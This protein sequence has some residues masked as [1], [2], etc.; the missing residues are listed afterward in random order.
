MNML[1]EI[2]GECVRRGDG[3]CRAGAETVARRGADRGMY[4]IVEY[5]RAGTTH[6][7]VCSSRVYYESVIRLANRYGRCLRAVYLAGGTSPP[8]TPPQFDSAAPLAPPPA[9]LVHPQRSGT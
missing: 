7:V 9:R 2:N 6:T 3:A 5:H 1:S 8:P 4:G